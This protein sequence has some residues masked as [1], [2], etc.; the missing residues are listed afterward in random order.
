MRFLPLPEL[1]ET[2]DVV[3][4]HMPL[5]SATRG[6]IGAA[7]LAA[8][9]A[10]GILVNTSR[11][12]LVNED[13]LLAALTSGTI[14]AAM[15]DTLAQEPPNGVSKALAAAS[16][17]VVTPHSAGSSWESWSRRCGNAVQN[18]E[19]VWAGLDPRWVAQP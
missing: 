13:A 6:I 17:C 8:L 14:R 2:S 15:L 18:V 11:G 19:R 12:D 1:L 4:L 7:E 3:S 5:T 9:G 10:D 16:R